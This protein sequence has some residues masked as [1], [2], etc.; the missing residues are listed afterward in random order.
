MTKKA[1]EKIVK[2]KFNGSEGITGTKFLT[3]QGSFAIKKNNELVRKEDTVVCYETP[4]TNRGVVNTSEGYLVA[5]VDWFSC[6]FTTAQDPRQ[7][8]GALLLDKITWTHKNTGINGYS[9]CW[10]YKNMAIFYNGHSENMGCFLNLSGQGC[11]DF[12]QHLHS[13]GFSWMEFFGYVLGFEGVNITRLDLAID[14]FHGYFNLKWVE[15]K[16][17]RALVRSK[18]R[19][20]RN[21]EEFDL[22]TGQTLGQT[23]YF[24]KNDVMV[25]F[26]DKWQERTQKGY[27][28]LE[29]TK[30]WVRTEIQL[31]GKRALKACEIMSYEWYSN[32]HTIGDFIKGVLRNYLNFLKEPNKGKPKDS[33]KARWEVSPEWLKFLGDVEKLKLTQVAPQKTILRTKDWIDKSVV[34]SLEMLALA[35]GDMNLFTEYLR[36]YGG[37]NISDDKLALAAEF[38]N[39]KTKQKQ[40]QDLLRNQMKADGKPMLKDDEI[41]AFIENIYQKSKKYNEEYETKEKELKLK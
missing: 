30:F 23:W 8:V 18:F 28:V 2:V 10:V 40:L 36:F 12:E 37:R 39:D 14:D 26:Y 32:D 22:K 15:R 27:K 19:T 24:G 41:N 16:V 1:L 7:I 38:I 6:T 17:K 31:R 4:L 5:C 3:P 13:I 20:A 21:F 11:R 34:Q 33:N 9:D 25:R 35:V 29:D